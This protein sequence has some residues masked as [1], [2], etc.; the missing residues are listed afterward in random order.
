MTNA[1][2]QLPESYNEPSVSYAPGSVERS[3][4]KAELE[5]QYHQVVDI[6]LIIGGQEVRTGKLHKVVCPHEHGHVLGH[7]HEAGEAE[8]AQAIDAALQAKF[9]WKYT[10]WE[11]RAAIFN[12]MASLI[13]GRY[14]YILNAATMLNQ[15]KTA[16]QAEIDATCETADF[17][18]YNA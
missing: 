13:S 12:R 2:F 5:R 6:P 1:I 15:S 4:L 18:R 10:P 17:L 8:I 9:A 7:Y 3:L 11:E 14:R 16:H